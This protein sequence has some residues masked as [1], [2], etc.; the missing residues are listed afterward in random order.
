MNLT[1]DKY[2]QKLILSGYNLENRHTI[3]ISG[4]RSF[5]KKLMHPEKGQIHSYRDMADTQSRR[6]SKS[7]EKT[8]WF[9][10]VIFNKKAKRKAEKLKH[11]STQTQKGPGWVDGMLMVPRTPDGGLCRS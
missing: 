1:L 6:I 3:F 2:N 5:K 9:N 11:K 7:S 8:Y 10:K 4:I